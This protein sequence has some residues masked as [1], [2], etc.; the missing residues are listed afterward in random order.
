LFA[1]LLRVALGQAHPD[2]T[3]ILKKVSEN[4]KAA[5]QYELVGDA[6]STTEKAAPSHIRIAFKANRYRM[7]EA[8]PG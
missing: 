2:V 3:Q 7:R 1:L 4:Y 8:C 6:N 5:A